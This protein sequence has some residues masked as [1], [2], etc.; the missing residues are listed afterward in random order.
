MA[1]DSYTPRRNKVNA[2]LHKAF[3]DHNID[4]Q[5]SGGKVYD[6]YDDWYEQEYNRQDSDTE[7]EKNPI[8]G[9]YAR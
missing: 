4:A 7:K 2:S 8:M 1:Y 6:N 5:T 9:V 3:Q